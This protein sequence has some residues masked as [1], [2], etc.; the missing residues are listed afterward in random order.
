MNLDRQTGYV[1]G[2]AFL[3]YANLKEAQNAINN[4]HDSKFKRKQI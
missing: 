2:Y 4:M 3:E 1:K